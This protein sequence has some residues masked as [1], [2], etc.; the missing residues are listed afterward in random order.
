MSGLDYR[1]LAGYLV[2]GTTWKRLRDLACKEKAFGG[3][4]LFKDGSKRCKDI[5][6]KSPSAIVDGRPET[7]LNFL[8]LLE[9][10][11]HVLHMLAT[12]DLS[13]RELG[14]AAKTAVLNLGSIK[15]RIR[16]RVL[17][18]LLE[19]CMFLKWW[20][21]KHKSIVVEASWDEL[22]RRAVDIILDLEVTPRVL[23]RFEVDDTVLEVI[24][25]KT[26]V[27]LA[28]LQVVGEAELRPWSSTGKCQTKLQ[29]T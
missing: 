23:Q 26:W 4:E 5:F 25:V 13:E 7:D 28:V 24:Q 3:L 11:E 16:R 14:T 22:M 19:R 2:D 9:G 18:E 17:Q 29:H 20:S 21:G 1:A 27:E 15:N 8:K 12:R 10:K 6:S